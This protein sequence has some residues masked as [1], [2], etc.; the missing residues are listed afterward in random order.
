MA[1]WDDLKARLEQIKT[2]K[3]NMYVPREK[4]NPNLIEIEPKEIG[5]RPKLSPEEL[6]DQMKANRG[7]GYQ[8]THKN[9]D[10]KR[11]RNPSRQEDW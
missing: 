10:G 11:K 3:Q 5:K 1:F 9:D 6:Q 7:T 4:K 2:A 8:R